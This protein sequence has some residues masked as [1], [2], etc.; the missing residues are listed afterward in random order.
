MQ[1]FHPA[2][3]R[4]GGED[5]ISCHKFVTGI[6]GGTSALTPADLQYHADIPSA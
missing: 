1:I 2:G 6:V 4:I 3:E 5:G